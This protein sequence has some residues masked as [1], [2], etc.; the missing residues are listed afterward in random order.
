MVWTMRPAH[1]S[2]PD[3]RA[4]NHHRQEE[5]NAD[6]FKPDSAA[7]ALEGSQ[8]SPNSAGNASGRLP[9]NL[10]C[11]TALRSA[12]R[13]VLSLNGRSRL[14]GCSLCAGGYSLARNASSD[15]KTDPKRATNGLG[16]H[17]DFDGNSVPMRPAFA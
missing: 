5:E 8:K 12:D 1:S 13:G 3:S 6:N 17:S 7:D 2:L 15:A 4:E 9:R 11:C 10:A 16:F 14:A